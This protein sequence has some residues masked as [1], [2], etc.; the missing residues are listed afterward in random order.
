MPELPEEK[1]RLATNLAM[2]YIF[3]GA[4]I[5]DVD[6]SVLS[7]EEAVCGIDGEPYIDGIDRSTSLGYPL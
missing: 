2:D 7:Y 1:V 5:E 4:Q 6:T 3:S